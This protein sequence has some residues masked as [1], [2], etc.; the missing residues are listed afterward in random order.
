MITIQIE[1]PDIAAALRRLSSGMVH[2]GPVMPV[3]AGIL[4]DA[5]M[6]NF[7]QGGRP[8]WKALEPATLAYKRFQSA[9]G[10]RAG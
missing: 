8:R 1:G 6:E 2:P 3:V 5:V 9:P 4:H 10:P 7:A